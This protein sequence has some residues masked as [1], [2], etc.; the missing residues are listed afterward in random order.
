M[1][2]M[3]EISE[4]IAEILL[5]YVVDHKITDPKGIDIMFKRVFADAEDY[6]VKKLAGEEVD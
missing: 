3:K 5:W 2:T 1:T 4:S 6:F